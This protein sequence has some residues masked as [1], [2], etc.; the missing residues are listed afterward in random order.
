VL[1][2]RANHGKFFKKTVYEPV[3]LQVNVTDPRFAKE[4]ETAIPMNTLFVS[5]SLLYI[6]RLFGKFYEIINND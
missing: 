4:V 1:W 2:L 3:I 6:T 5:F